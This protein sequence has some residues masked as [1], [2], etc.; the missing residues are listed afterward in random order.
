[1]IEL[2]TAGSVQQKP[3]HCRKVARRTEPRIFLD[4]DGVL[5]NAWQGFCDLF[6]KHPECNPLQYE[7]TEIFDIREKDF[8]AR[9]DQ[10]PDFWYK[11]QPYPWLDELLML[12][13]KHGHVAIC[14]A[15][16]GSVLQ[17]ERWIEKYI[18]PEMQLV[19]T[20]TKGLLAH[21]DAILIDD[22]NHNVLEFEAHG[23]KGITF[24]Q[25]WNMA[26]EHI[27]NRLG[28]VEEQLEA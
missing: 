14:T 26:F 2:D 7:I 28:Y 13:R 10:V 12:C 9:I 20:T 27:N 21:A 1:M 19:V 25:P 23:G 5:V 3:Q 15:G 11:L 24:P 17:K 18:G 6:E 16:M 4:M 8:W 22:A